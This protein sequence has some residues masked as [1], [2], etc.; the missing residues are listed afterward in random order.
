MADDVFYSRLSELT[1]GNVKAEKDLVG[2]VNHYNE[3]LDK[4]Q[5][6]FEPKF[7]D[8]RA[9]WAYQLLQANPGKELETAQRTIR[10]L[11]LTDRID[12]LSPKEQL[13][14][15]YLLRPENSDMTE[16]QAGPLFEAMYLKK[17]PDLETD[18]LQQREHAVEARQAKELISKII[19]E[20]AAVEAPAQKI[21]KDVEDSIV[22]TVGKFAGIRLAFTDNPSEADYMN[23]PLADSEAQA[24]QESALRPDVWM[25]EFIDQFKG[26]NN[27]YDY[28]AY[29]REGWEMRNHK[30]IRQMAYDHGFK[31]G[32][33]SQINKARNASTPAEI[34]KLGGGPPPPAAKETFFGNWEQAEKERAARMKAS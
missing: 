13:F 31:M 11:S 17:Y 25:S 1:G 22:S 15:A 6:G 20:R 3:L 10:A 24:L 29:V 18:L 19:S 16:L 2:W 4:E 7:P 9:K 27:T 21:S 32:E 5:K 33:L 23:V 8:E 34:N 14:Q 30:P 28:D 12:K 26:P